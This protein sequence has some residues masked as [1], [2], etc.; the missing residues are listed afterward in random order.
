M[1]STGWSRLSTLSAG[2]THH[3]Q[4]LSF[5]TILQNAAGQ[6]WSR[7]AAGSSSYYPTVHDQKLH[8]AVAG[9][10][11]LTG[12]SSANSSTGTFAQKLSR[13]TARARIRREK[14]NLSVHYL[15][16]DSL[17]EDD[18]NDGAVIYSAAYPSASY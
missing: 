10:R 8:N 3:L 14:M 17:A 18:M 15:H 9:R 6:A 1:L 7:R 16:P 5:F 4:S 13:P 12:C 2:N 11:N